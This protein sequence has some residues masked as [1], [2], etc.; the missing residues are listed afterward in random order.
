[1]PPLPPLCRRQGRAGCLAL[2]GLFQL[3]HVGGS[4]RDQFKRSG[5]L[6]L[7]GRGNEDLGICCRI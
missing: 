1:M 6:G 2:P 4:Q 3:M 7:V 5:A